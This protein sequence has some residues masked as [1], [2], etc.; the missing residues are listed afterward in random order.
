MT[1]E[2]QLQDD[3]KA[4]MRSRDSVRL[5]VIRFIRSEIHNEQISKQAELSDEDVILVLSRLAQQ[6]RDSIEAF[7]QGN[8]K[9]LADKEKGEL[10]I[11]LEYLPVQMTSDEIT[12]LARKVIEEVAANGAQDM[13]KVMG[14]IVPQVRGRAEGRQVSAIVM[15][16][17]SARVS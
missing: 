2:A 13:G 4:A 12:E 15:K 11:V 3:M 7:T 10:A 6:R 9:E 16:L 1:L 8:R 14:R 17:L 5:G